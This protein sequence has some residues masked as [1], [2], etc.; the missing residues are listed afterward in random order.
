VCLLRD[1]LSGLEVF[2]MRR[3]D[4]MRFAPGV[5]VFPGG[6]VE[7]SDAHVP[8]VPG[9]DWSALGTRAA[10]GRPLALVAAAVRETFEE[11]GVLLA[12]P[13]TVTPAPLGTDPDS[14]GRDRAGRSL[15]EDRVE[16]YEGR[17]GFADVLARRGLVIDP[18]LLPLMSHWVTP[19]VES[20]RFDTRFFTAALPAGQQ[21]SGAGEESTRSAWESPTKALLAYAAGDFAMWPPTVATLHWL[22]E[23]ADVAATLRAAGEAVVRPVMPLRTP[24]ASGHE[25]WGLADHRTGQRLAPEDTSVTRAAARADGLPAPGASP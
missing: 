5:H 9:T 2:M 8:V 20:R 21:A 16:L 10:S 4:T 22:A 17:L 13:A 12:V 18:S 3:P 7:D 6:A 23:H 14:A 11:C 25:H 15:A 19:E 24:D 1:G